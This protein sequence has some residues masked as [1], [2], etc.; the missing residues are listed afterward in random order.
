VI[1]E[2]GKMEGSSK[3]TDVRNDDK[4]ALFLMF[5]GVACVALLGAILIA[6]VYWGI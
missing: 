5:F 1:G 2:T 3:R 4:L 6:Y